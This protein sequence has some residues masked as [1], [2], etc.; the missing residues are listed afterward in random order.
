[1]PN[2][3]MGFSM[4]TMVSLSEG[5]P[6]WLTPS[7]P[8][9]QEK[10]SDGPRDTP[11]EAAP[12]APMPGAGEEPPERIRRSRFR[13]PAWIPRPSTTVWGVAFAALVETAILAWVQTQ[14][15]F[16]F[17]SRQG[18]LGAYNQAFY[19][20]VHGQG[21]FYYTVN[22]SGGTN[23]T[24]WAVHFSPTLVLLVPLYA[25]A[26]SPVTLIILKQAALALGA[27][28]IYGIARVYFRGG[29]VPV[30]FAA[31]YLI[32][33]LT[34]ANDWNNFDPE[35]LVPLLLLVAMY[36]FTVGRFWSFLIFWLLTLG[37]MESMPPLLILFTVGGLV[38][39]FLGP[40]R[41]PYWTAVQ[42][43]RPLL[44]ALGAAGIWL[45][46]AY[47]ALSLTGRGGGFGSSYGIR[48]QVLGATSLPDVLVRAVT[49]PG[50]AGAALQFQ[51]S[52]K[53][54]FLAVVILASGAISILGG[55]RY[56]LPVVGY[57]SLAFLSSNS[58]LYVFGSEFVPMF[59]AFLFVGAIEG[60]VLVSDLINGVDAGQ[61]HRDLAFQ[62]TTQ[63]G[64]FLTELQTVSP[65]TPTH[66]RAREQ[67]RL[68]DK[69]LASDELGTAERGLRRLRRELGGRTRGLAATQATSAPHAVGAS[70][71]NAT[72]STLRHFRP[73]ISPNRVNGAMAATL[74][75]LV[76][77]V[78][79]AS[80]YANPLL[81]SPAAGGSQITF[82]LHGPNAHERALE[83]LLESIPP[84]A[85]VLTTSHLFPELSSRP[86]AYVVNNLTNLPD[87]VTI[88]DA[89]DNWLNQS[90][91]VAI[92][93]RVDPTNAVILQS[94]A[95]LTSN[96]SGFGVYA[97]MDGA[98]IY[99]RNWGGIPSVLASWNST[100]A[101]GQLTT[102]YGNASSQFA[103]SQGPSYYHSNLS[104]APGNYLWGGPRL[105]YLPPG[106]YTVSFN[107]ELQTPNPGPQLK[108]EV[109]DTPAFVNEKVVLN[110]GGY[111]YRQIV[112]NGT[113]YTDGAWKVPPVE[114]I[115]S[116]T[117]LSQ[118]NST[119]SLSH[120][121]EKMS[122]TWTSVGYLSFPG[123]ELSSTMSVYLISVSLAQ[124][125]ATV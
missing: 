109:A 29:V 20:T 13:I 72:W 30:L 14:N 88:K 35:C 112:I 77:C 64:N 55:L 5:E 60:T 68:D 50:A 70:A 104:G 8:A 118:A 23:G 96:V 36:F 122:F 45:A 125:S 25:I 19:T 76:V 1:M 100:W 44:I 10:E 121:V 43:R 113:N 41:S 49:H 74:A 3:N 22:I 51:G 94:D 61:R 99:E 56:I 7:L 67:L 87:G 84:Q 42:Q 63:V 38:G 82:G 98:Y 12:V 119:T 123:I 80:A 73:R 57:L 34:I 106:Q 66:V 11:R 89:I 17:H 65:E 15:Y 105:I 92:D 62:L 28:P 9:R 95:D 93:Y 40:S 47:G 69:L 101:G 124:T 78:L 6:T 59:S 54:L 71:T 81:N 85:S 33:P 24:L 16:G 37:V 107:L 21:F 32:S 75:I 52:E 110:Y 90:S 39:T 46:V 97:A 18:D 2:L 117:V 53:I 120:E 4:T 31:L 108:L 83:S 102:H 86:D 103:S 116:L 48:Y 26:A 27:I 111:S 91:F 58:T 115:K 114:V 79:A